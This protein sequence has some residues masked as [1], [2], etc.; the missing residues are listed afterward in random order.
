[1]MLATIFLIRGEIRVNYSGKFNS[2]KVKRSFVHWRISHL[3]L[4]AIDR[5]LQLLLKRLPVE[6][7]SLVVCA[8]WNTFKYFRSRVSLGRTGT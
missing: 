2:A 7:I 8:M 3:D 5:E 4:R 6:V 1:M